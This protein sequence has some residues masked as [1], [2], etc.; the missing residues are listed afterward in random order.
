MDDDRAR[1][2]RALGV[3]EEEEEREWSCS[4]I[5]APM[6]EN[7]LLI[8]LYTKQCFIFTGNLK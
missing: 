6:G 8:S 7:F 2:Y 1:R 5:S 4:T 3:V